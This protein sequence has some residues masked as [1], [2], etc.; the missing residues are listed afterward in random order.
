MTLNRR[1]EQLLGRNATLSEPIVNGRGQL[2]IDDTVWRCG[3]S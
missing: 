3:G 2:K 1:G